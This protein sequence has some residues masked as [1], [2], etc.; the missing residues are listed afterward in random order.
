[1]G[2]A[3]GM[4]FPIIP[5]VGKEVGLSVPFIG[6]ILAANRAVRVVA[7]PLVGTPSSTT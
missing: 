3:G 1:M 6:V 7:S 2:I 4:V 5:I